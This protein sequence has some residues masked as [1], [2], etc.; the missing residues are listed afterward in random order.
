MGPIISIVSA[1][2]A[3][4]FLLFLEQCDV[5]ADRILD[6]FIKIRQYNGKGKLIETYSRQSTKY[7]QLEKLDPAELD[8]LLSEVTVLQTRVELYF[9]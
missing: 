2:V 5:E 6:Q 9:K 4:E 7:A 8:L 3:I 1:I